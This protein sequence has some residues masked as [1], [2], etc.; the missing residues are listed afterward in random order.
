MI[1]AR[2]AAMAFNRLADNWRPLFA[3][4]EIAG[5]DWPQRACD[6]FAKLNAKED[7]DAEGLGA[8]LL[9]D[10]RDILTRTDADPFPSAALAEALIELEDR[11]WPDFSHGKPITKQRV[12]RMLKKFGILSA[13]KRVGDETFKGYDRCSFD[14]AFA[15]YLPPEIA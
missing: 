5:S 3:I 8:M 9:S 15:R 7:M 4:A 11:P 13:T 1:S 10:I 2:S 12:S 6:A 14:D